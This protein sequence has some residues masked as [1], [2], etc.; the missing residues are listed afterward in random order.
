[1]VN[2]L[3][4]IITGTTSYFD[5]CI[6]V[7]ICQYLLTTYCSFTWTYSRITICTRQPHIHSTLQYT[8]IS[9]HTVHFN[10][11]H[12]SFNLTSDYPALKVRNSKAGNYKP[13]SETC[14]KEL[15]AVSVHQALWYLLTLC[16]LVHQLLQLLGG[17][18]DPWTSR[19]RRCSNWILLWS[20]VQ[21]KYRNR[22][23]ILSTR[24]WVSIGTVW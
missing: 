23:K 7:C 19:W 15:P 4:I 24:T 22:N 17:E 18:Q 3:P 12:N 21:S 6:F 14:S 8:N 11:Q 20:V 13:T 2:K 1:M 16:F 5:F 9:T 10:I